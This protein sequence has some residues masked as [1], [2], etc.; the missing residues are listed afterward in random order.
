MQK[1][2]QPEIHDTCPKAHV[3][4]GTVAEQSHLD[5]D[6]VTLILTGIQNVRTVYAKV[7]P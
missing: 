6:M 1:F 4:E 7:V 5:L 3:T 2:K